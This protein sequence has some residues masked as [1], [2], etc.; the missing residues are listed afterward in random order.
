MSVEKK[1]LNTFQFTKLNTLELLEKWD[2]ELAL[3]WIK[4]NSIETVKNKEDKLSWMYELSEFI[5]DLNNENIKK[6]CY[7]CDNAFNLNI[8]A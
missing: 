8:L 1:E 4:I 5:G 6:I 2:I 7:I 3:N